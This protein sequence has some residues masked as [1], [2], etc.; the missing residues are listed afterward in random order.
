MRF[1]EGNA[2]AMPMLMSFFLMIV[3][4]STWM[5][6]IGISFIAWAIAMMNTGVKVIFS[7]SR[8][9]KAFFT[10]LRQSTRLVTSASTK[11]VTW[12]LMCLLITMWSAISFRMRSISIS[13]SPG[14][15]LMLGA[16]GAALA[17]MA[18]GAVAG[19]G[20]SGL[21]PLPTFVVPRCGR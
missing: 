10:L 14:P 18:V 13:S 17:A 19:A 21:L 8:F 7:P 2:A 4:P 15:A 9:S 3:V 5:L 12:G 16:T 6:I 11:L 20:C 1:P